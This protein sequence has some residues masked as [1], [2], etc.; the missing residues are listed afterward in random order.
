MPPRRASRGSCWGQCGAVR[1]LMK[2]QLLRRNVKRFRGGLVG[3]A[4][5]LYHST[6]GSRVMKKRREAYL[7]QK[8]ADRVLELVGAALKEVDVVQIRQRD[9]PRHFQLQQ[10]R[11]SLV[12]LFLDTVRSSYNTSKRTYVKSLRVGVGGACLQTL[13]RKQVLF[14][15][16][17]IL[18]ENGTNNLAKQKSEH[19]FVKQN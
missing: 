17:C 8:D 9:V 11:H 1:Y 7:A 13:V 5:R 4:H 15:Q 2:E 12:H 18:G 10:M 6:L 16:K 19:G 14:F 3:T